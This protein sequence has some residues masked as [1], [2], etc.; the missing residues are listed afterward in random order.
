MQ[1]DSPLAAEVLAAYHR[2]V[3]GQ[4]EVTALGVLTDTGAEHCALSAQTGLGE[5]RGRVD[6]GIEFIRADDDQLKEYRWNPRAHARIEDDPIADQLSA[7]RGQG[8]DGAALL[9]TI[10][11]ALTS[12]VDDGS[13]DE[14]APGAV[15][16]PLLVD[17]PATTEQWRARLNPGTPSA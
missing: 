1:T 10:L 13:L 15:R 4:D 7:L 16:A 14:L 6:A 17:D 2:L 8:L 12:L 9:D 11:G 3:Q 5:L